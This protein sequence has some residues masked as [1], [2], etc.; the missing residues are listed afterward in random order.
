MNVIVDTATKNRQLR[1]GRSVSVLPA[2]HWRPPHLHGT[3]ELEYT[4]AHLNR[5]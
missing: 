3:A 4:L 5:M 2:H 1:R